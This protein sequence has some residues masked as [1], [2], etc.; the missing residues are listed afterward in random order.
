VNLSARQF[1]SDTLIDDIAET[2]SAYDVSPSQ[3][4]V[5]LTESVLM[6]DPDRANFVLH[7]LHAM[8]VHISIDDFGTGYSSLSYLKRFPANTV[9]ID[10]SFVRGL[11]DDKNDAAITQAVIA[12]AHSL[13]LS[14]VAEG[15]ESDA[16]LQMLRRLGCD[17]AQG[18][19]LGRPMPARELMSRLDSLIP[20]PV[21]ANGAHGGI[22]RC[23]SETVG[24]SLGDS[25]CQRSSCR[26]ACAGN[27]AGHPSIQ[28]YWAS[29]ALPTSPCRNAGCIAASAAMTSR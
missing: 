14:V 22:A 19:L 15:V 2:M 1:A 10:R 25:T 20:A 3:F 18:Y 23:N 4:E 9:K 16:Q 29:S 26:S 5:E 28:P 11:P 12:M 6:A 17:E 7:Q 27:A 24:N 21:H 13:G 8:G